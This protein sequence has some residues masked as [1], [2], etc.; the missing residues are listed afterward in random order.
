MPPPHLYKL[1]DDGWNLNAPPMPLKRPGG[2]ENHAPRRSRGGFGS[3][4]LHLVIDAGGVHLG[5]LVA[6]G[7]SHESRSFE[8]VMDTVRIGRRQRPDARSLQR[9][10]WRW[11]DAP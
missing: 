7:Q 10:T 11:S 4:K 9:T 8:A 1:T 6:A 5:V 3:S 2:P